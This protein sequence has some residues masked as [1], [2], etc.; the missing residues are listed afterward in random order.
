MLAI[1]L[2]LDLAALVVQSFGGALAATAKTKDGANRGGRS[3]YLPSILRVQW[4]IDLLC[5]VMMIGIITQL[6]GV[7]IFAFIAVD[8]IWR[9]SVDRPA[10]GNAPKE[11]TEALRPRPAG[12]V[13][14]SQPLRHLLIGMGISTFL[15][16]IRFVYL[17]R[18]PMNPLTKPSAGRFTGLSNSQTVGTVRS[19]PQ[20]GTSTCSMLLPSSLL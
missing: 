2:T 20:S 12:Y 13:S 7:V 3:E 6:A 8:F 14:A 19:S 10:R 5:A 17:F 9:I 4:K 15:I 1:F 16:V 11:S 18:A